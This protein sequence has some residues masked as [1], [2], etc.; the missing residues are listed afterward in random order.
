M[1]LYDL[2][3]S[4]IER[5]PQA[6]KA[7]NVDTFLYQNLIILMR[8]STVKWTIFLNGKFSTTKN[9]LWMTF[10]SNKC[11]MAEFYFSNNE[12]NSSLCSEEFHM[13]LIKYTKCFQIHAIKFRRW[14]FEP[15]FQKIALKIDI[16]FF[17]QL[18]VLEK[19]FVNKKCFKRNN[20]FN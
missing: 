2:S 1:L 8:S 18:L 14:F 4:P 17:L 12:M 20:A 9:K 13:L 6:R 7:I 3:Y 15:T 10:D 16:W 11:K 5:N 19:N